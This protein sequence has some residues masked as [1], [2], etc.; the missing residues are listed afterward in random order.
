LGTTL[1]DN[2]TT[3]FIYGSDYPIIAFDLGKEYIIANDTD[4]LRK[5]HDTV[6][7]NP[8]TSVG[9]ID[10]QFWNGNDESNWTYSADPSSHTSRPETVNFRT[11]GA[12]VPDF[13]VRWAAVK[14]A[15]KLQYIPSGDPPKQY[16]FQTPGL[17]L[18]YVTF[19]PRNPEVFTENA[20]WFSNKKSVLKD[21]STFAP[22]IG[23]PIVYTDGT[24]YGSAAGVTGNSSSTTA[25]NI[26]DPYLAFDGQFDEFDLDFTSHWGV[27][28]RNV[29]TGK[30]DSANAFPHSIWRVFRNPQTGVYE[31]KSVKAVFIRGANEDFYPTTFQIQ[32]L[33]EDSSGNP[34][35]PNLNSSWTTIPFASFSNIDTFQ[36]GF[37]FT[38]IFTE[39]VE[40]KGIRIRISNSAYVDDSSVTSTDPDTGTNK[41]TVA[42]IS[43]PQTRVSEII[44]YEEVVSE[45]ALTG[46]IETDHMRSAIVSSLTSTPDHGPD[47]LQDGDLDTYWQSSGFTDTL[48]IT[49]PRESPI[50]RLEWELDQD[51]QNQSAQVSTN[52]PY[53]FS[54]R[55]VVDGTEREL[56]VGSGIE[57]TFF[58]QDLEGAPITA[59][60]FTFEITE[61]QGRH[62]EANSII[63]NELRL[64]EVEERTAPLTVI[65]STQ[66]RRPEGTNKLATKFIYAADTDAI[67]KITAD[68]WDGNNDEYWS[69][70]DFFSIWI[71]INDVSL[72]DTSFGNFKLGNDSDTFYRW[73]FKNLNLTSGWQQVLLQF[74]QA[75]DKS[76]IPFKPG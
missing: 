24:D 5:R 47:Q 8:D 59:K 66:E 68:G 25:N 39:A 72:L 36:E 54:L 71:Y 40:T 28:L 44:I 43:G 15:D 61:P 57:G 23:K 56:V 37:G 53:N 75:D 35:D 7:P 6:G 74:R 14:I 60:D 4:V 33:K 3:T 32:S 9:S 34:R 46:T 26:G 70:R 64:I 27:A 31:T 67:A 13:P 17:T 65:E 48:T 20:V 30:N 49:L 16:A 51:F 10:R 2:K 62:E 41:S 21:I 55:G 58:S 19:K 45:S 38:H 63:I 11:F 50:T 42:N 73:D 12:G 52:G 18:F 69:E 1:S 22:T 29:V 76:E